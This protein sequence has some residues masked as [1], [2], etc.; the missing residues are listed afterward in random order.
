MGLD[1]LRASAI[2]LPMQV[3]M[4]RLLQGVIDYAGLFPPAKLAMRPSVERYVAAIRGD[5]EWIVSRFVCTASRLGELADVLDSSRD[6]PYL[7]VSAV[8]TGGK[9]R[10]EWEA[11]LTADAAAMNAFQKRMGDRADVEGFE[12]RVPDHGG[13][14]GYIR[15]LN[16]FSDA[17]I[18]VELPWGNG[19]ADSISALAETDWLA[20]KGR[21]G[22]LE[23]SA[24]PNAAALSQFIRSCVDLELPFKLTAG[25]HHPFPGHDESVGATTHGFLNVLAATALAISDDMSAREMERLLADG[26]P[27]AWRFEAKG[28]TWRGRE[29]L[30]DDIDEARDLFVSFGSCSIDEPLADLSAAFP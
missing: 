24:I 1:T 22:G 29:A 20:A 3:S 11:G 12:S 7:A 5:E 15:D 26:D 2:L 9:N 18:F 28:F 25:L 8:G 6:I 14:A 21:T 23:P 10:E 17:E 4:T 30:L 19:M 16:G 13:I 27:Q